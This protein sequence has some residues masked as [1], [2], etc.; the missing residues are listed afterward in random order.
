M[1]LER[2]SRALQCSPEEATEIAYSLGVLFGDTLTNVMRELQDTQTALQQCQ[3]IIA[4]FQNL[5][6]DV[7]IPEEPIEET[8]DEDPT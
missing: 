2:L 5:M 7:Q 8:S 1:D 3:R 4:H 6:P